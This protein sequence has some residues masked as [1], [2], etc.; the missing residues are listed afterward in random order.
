MGAGLDGFGADYE[1]FLG[2]LKER[3]RSA[4]VRAAVAV[5]R[6]LVLLYWG[7]GRDI[8]TRRQELGWGAGVIERLSADLRREF[9][10]MRGFSERNLR[11]MTT[12]AETHP[13]LPNLQVPLADLTWYHNIAL[14]EKVKGR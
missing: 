9:P 12:F 10:E 7:I 4:Q 6:E 14:L 13:D 11:Y 1:E 2:A 3:V 8:L 5:N